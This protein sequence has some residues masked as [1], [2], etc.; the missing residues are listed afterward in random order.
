MS[1][2]PEVIRVYTGIDINSNLIIAATAECDRLDIK[3]TALFK[4]FQPGEKCL[5]IINSVKQQVCLFV[6][7]GMKFHAAPAYTVTERTKG[8]CAQC[9]RATSGGYYRVYAITLRRY[10]G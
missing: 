1:S 8:T 4:A 3:T 9:H 7:E 10:S 5:E 2:Y 6:L